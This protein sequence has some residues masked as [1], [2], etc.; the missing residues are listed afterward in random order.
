MSDIYEN[1]ATE[2]I[3][4]E[5]PLTKIKKQRTQKQ[6]EAFEKVKQ[7]RKENLEAKKQEKLS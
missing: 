7:K 2:E 5:V 4:E 1:E 6:M 3:N